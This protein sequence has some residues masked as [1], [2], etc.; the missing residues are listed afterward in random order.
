MKLAVIGAGG[1]SRIAHGQCL[2]LLVEK[3]GH[4]ISLAAVCDLDEERA[5]SY[6]DDYGFDSVY[7]DTDA[8][9]AQEKPDGILA[10]TPITL[11]VPL[12]SKWLE[13]GIPMLIEKPPGATS[14]EAQILLDA[15]QKTGTPH[16]L[17]FNRRFD[18]ALTRALDWM[19]KNDCQPVSMLARMIRRRRREADFVLGTGVHAIDTVLSVMGNPLSGKG[20]RSAGTADKR[21]SFS[22]TLRFDGDRQAVLMIAPDSAGNIETYEFFASD[23][24]VLVD[25]VGGRAEAWRDGESVFSWETPSDAPAGNQSSSLEE[26]RAFIES[27]AGKRAWAPDLTHGYLVMQVAELIHEGAHRRW[28]VPTS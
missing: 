15:A 23:C 27:V 25:T 12:V 22:G 1:H 28:Q 7:T 20:E 11:T 4:D 3:G 19:R 17:S 10:I 2:K 16:M 6:A 24:R 8:M 14:T 26:N 5:R 9:V 21:P 13:Y 18:P